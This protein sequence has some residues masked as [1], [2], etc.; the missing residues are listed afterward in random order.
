MI[1]EADAGLNVDACVDYGVV[2]RA[3]GHHRLQNR[4]MLRYGDG[5]QVGSGAY[6]Q[7]CVRSPP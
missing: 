7:R 2:V 6:M 3:Y 1:L 4:K 5:K